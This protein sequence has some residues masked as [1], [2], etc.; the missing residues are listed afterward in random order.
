[1]SHLRDRTIRLANSNPELRDL[2][3]T[4][5]E[6]SAATF[7]GQ[8]TGPLEEG[9]VRIYWDAP[10]L[11]AM[12]T[13]GESGGK[14]IGKVRMGSLTDIPKVFKKLMSYLVGQGFTADSFVWGYNGTSGFTQE[15]LSAAM[16]RH[17]TSPQRPSARKPFDTMSDKSL[18]SLIQAWSS[19]N[20]DAVFGDEPWGS[21]ARVFK[22]W[23]GEMKTWDAE[24]Q[25]DFIKSLSRWT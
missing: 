21:D 7:I 15:K 12:Y 25:E 3:L 8:T 6:A 5:K 17:M 23:L 9:Q 2:L 1:M 19:H 4:I 16:G 20:P 13:H 10:M 22:Y 11:S 14:L 18:V 24:Q